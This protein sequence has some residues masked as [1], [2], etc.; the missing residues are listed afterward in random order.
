MND[1]QINGGCRNIGLSNLVVAN[2]LT[3]VWREA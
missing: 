1:F 3:P 2:L